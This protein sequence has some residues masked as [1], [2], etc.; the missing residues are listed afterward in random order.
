M[1]EEEEKEAKKEEKEAKK[2]ENIDPYSLYMRICNSENLNKQFENISDEE[3]LQSILADERR[4]NMLLRNKKTTFSL[5]EKF[6]K[7][8]KPLTFENVIQAIEDGNLNIISENLMKNPKK[9]DYAVRY[10]TKK[11]SNVIQRQDT[12]KSFKQEQ[13]AADVVICETSNSRK[14]SLGRISIKTVKD[15]EICDQDYKNEIENNHKNFEIFEYENNNEDVNNHK[16][17][18]NENNENNNENVDD[19]DAIKPTTPAYT[20]GD[21][22]ADYYYD[23]E[24]DE[25]E[26][27]NATNATFETIEEPSQESDPE[28]TICVNN[29]SD[30]YCQLSHSL[31]SENTLLYMKNNCGQVTLDANDL[32][33]ATLKTK[34]KYN[35]IIDNDGYRREYTENVVLPDHRDYTF[36]Y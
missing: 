28:Q 3:L 31:S 12:K 13:Q 20:I 36:Q 30:K 35:F 29:L 1:R 14:P 33:I 27:N 22:V 8:V 11:T 4:A 24:N 32:K 7:E 9:F 16:I 26:K 10:F 17:E 6:K 2:E 5:R 19:F 15:V 25:N 23:D 18:N 21:I 34:P